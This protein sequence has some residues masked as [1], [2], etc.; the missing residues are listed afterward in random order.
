M[1]RS[2]RDRAQGAE[3][4]TVY[5]VAYTIVA[6]S[7]RVAPRLRPELRRLQHLRRGRERRRERPVAGG[8]AQTA[9]SHPATSASAATVRTRCWPG[10]S[11]AASPGHWPARRRTR[12]TTS[13]PSRSRASPGA[14]RGTRTGRASR[15][16]T[17]DRCGPATSTR[18]ACRGRRPRTSTRASS[19]GVAFSASSPWGPR[20]RPIS[21]PRC[22]SRRRANS[23]GWRRG[24][25]CTCCS[26][27]RHA[28]R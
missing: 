19:A 15:S 9:R 21:P 10:C 24:P 12:S 8:G 27:P 3:G 2:Q 5:D 23:S 25:S 22:W 6:G 20:P 17:T 14:R 16:R 26:G 1:A 7:F 28:R 4:A 18:R 13:F 11:R